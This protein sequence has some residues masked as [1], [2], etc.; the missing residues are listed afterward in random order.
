MNELVELT[1]IVGGYNSQS[2]TNSIAIDRA[3]GAAILVGVMKNWPANSDIQSLVCHLLANI[4]SN[5]SAFEESLMG[6]GG[7]D[8]VATTMKRFPFVQNLQSN[9]CI[10][11]GCMTTNKDYADHLVNKLEAHLLVITAMNRFPYASSL[12]HAAS[13]V[14]CN[15]SHWDE[16]KAAIVKAEGD[17]ALVNAIKNITCTDESADH[18]KLI[19]KSARLAL[20][21]LNRCLGCHKKL[22][23]AMYCS[24]CNKATYCSKECQRKD[25]KIHKHTE[26][27]EE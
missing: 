16:F 1:S 22:K 15:L 26:C 4:T 13:W 10:V 27:S 17:H 12:Q 6:A 18:V 3:G 23:K 5:H 9:A 11:L 21:R 25:W 7:L 20:L 8:A 14:L 24:R 19:H 2:I